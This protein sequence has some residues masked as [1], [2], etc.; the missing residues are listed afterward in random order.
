MEMKDEEIR[1]WLTGKETN[2]RLLLSTLHHVSKHSEFELVLFC[3]RPTNSK[4][5]RDFI[6]V[7]WSNSNWHAIP[8]SNLRD[9]SQ[10]KKAYQKARLCLHPD[11]LQQRGGASPIQ[12]SVASRVFAILQVLNR[13]R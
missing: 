2:I 9:G 4:P 3:V 12:K 11:K 7:L 8:L 5:N 13:F 6:Q 1:I 10:V